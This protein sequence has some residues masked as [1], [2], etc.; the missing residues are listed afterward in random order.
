MC[1][2][3]RHFDHITKHSP[4]GLQSLS[5]ISQKIMLQAASIDEKVADF[6]WFRHFTSLLN[7]MNNL[8]RNQEN[9]TNRSKNRPVSGENG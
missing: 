6:D 7:A 3:A 1:L 8:K 9:F 4:Y 2:Y 5:D